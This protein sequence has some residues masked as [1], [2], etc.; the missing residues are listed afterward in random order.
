MSYGIQILNG[1]GNAQIDSD[2][3]NIGITVL[4]S[5]A[6]SQTCTADLTY[7]LVFA[8]PVA[9]SGSQTIA[10]D[11]T[12][13]NTSSST[14]TFRNN[15]GTAINASFIVAR[16]SSGQTASSSGYG[17]QVYNEDGDL[18]FDTGFYNGNSG[19]GITVFEPSMS[20][21]GDYDFLSNDLSQYSLMN[22][23]FP[24]NNSLNFFG[25]V[26]RHTTGTTSP[27]TSG[28]GIYNLSYVYINALGIGQIYFPN[29]GCLFL[30]KGGSV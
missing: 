15:A 25:Y 4:S 21:N 17:I 20:L 27:Y 26:Y 12:G 19:L 6:S 9:T 24:S 29:F 8:K 14:H 3:S 1:N 10:M 13:N 18:A 7:D 22:P 16:A 2:T 28:P 11:T 23:T 30:A 5:A